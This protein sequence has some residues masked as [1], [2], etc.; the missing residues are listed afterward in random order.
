MSRLSIRIRLTLVFAVAMAAVIAAMGLF[1]YLR[2]D[3][4]L[5]RSLD[6]SLNAQLNE[7]VHRSSEPR[8]LVD[9][10][11]SAL[12]QV[13]SSKGKVVRST[14]PS[15]RPLLSH[16]D[17]EEVDSGREIERSGSV[18]GLSGQWRIRAVPVRGSGGSRM[19][20]VVIGSLRPVQ[21]ALDHLLTQLLIAG[22][23][24][25]LL[26]ALG[27]Y[28]LAASALHPV[29]AMRR[30]A[31]QISAA[32]PGHRLPVP[33]SGDEIARL[34]STLNDMLARIE[35]AMEHERR[36]V[37]DASHELRTPLALLR[38]EIELALRRRRSTAELERALRSAALE[39][40]RLS[41]LAEDL[42]LIARSD[43]GSLPIR[44]ER[45]RVS[46]LLG[47]VASRFG[48][49]AAESGRQIE[50]VPSNGLLLDA[51]P[52]RL[53]QAL[54]NLVG[55]ALE[56]GRGTVRLSAADGDTV[57]EIHVTDEG[58]GF[59][60]GFLERAFERF[61]RGDEARGRGGSGL[62]LAI[63]D[64]VARAHGGT[65]GARNTSSGAD[66]WLALPVS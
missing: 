57:V 14:P 11:S 42:L 30:R 21:N 37:A 52:A 54:G 6:Q 64:V 33:P 32:T 43:R 15:A 50:V 58:A 27:G 5:I 10:D 26:A 2:L 48:A 20:A 38:T 45:V 35:D 46:D 13:I 36:F 29:E 53:E 3:S 25:V 8:G 51:D 24:A 17:L 44:H 18:Q 39:T 19:A 23:I 60:A 28:V 61:S 47:T 41:R 16:G 1:L 59:P 55:N 12:A 7:A 56:H 49:T 65:A 4:S 31:E 40:D 9:R 22:P 62:G 66:V 63:V 34:G